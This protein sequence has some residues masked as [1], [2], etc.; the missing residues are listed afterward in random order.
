MKE[1]LL[2]QI[3][4]YK[5]FRAKIKALYYVS[6][7]VNW[8][9]ETV[10]PRDCFDYR[11]EQM[12]IINEELIKTSLSTEYVESINYIYNN[13]EELEDDVL[14]HEIIEIK[15]SNDKMKKIPME[16][17]V[18][19]SIL[20]SKSV[21]VWKDAKKNNSFK[22]FLPVLSEIINYQRKYVK[23]LE[24]EDKKGYDILLDEYE[25]GM[26]T[27][28]YDE[29]FN[30]LKEKLVPFLKK[31]LER[32]NDFDYKF[33]SK[34]YKVE[35]QKKVCEYFRD[36]MCFDKNKGIMIETEH[37]FTDKVGTND[38][39][40][41]VH[42]YEKLF[43]SSIY[44]VI[45]ETGHATYEANIDKSLEGTFSDSGASMAMHESQ[46]RFYENI[47]GKNELFLKKHYPFIKS[48]YKNNLKD[49]SEEY[50]VRYCNL[51]EASYIRTEADELTYPIH[52]MLRYDLEKKL[53]SGE[54]KVKDLEKEWNKLFFEYFGLKVKKS[55]EGVLQDTHWAGGSFGYFPTYA[56][57]SAYAAQFLH[58]MK[59]DINF[60]EAVSKDNTEEINNWLKEHI[61][62]Y[63]SSKDPKE[64][65]KI[66]TGED[67]NPNYYVD[68]LI[69]KYS[70]L[71]N[72]K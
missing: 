62:K 26:S 52:I 35:D 34:K 36:V 65:I 48:V 14:K 33:A 10:A 6:S 32:G 66:A 28:E 29:F 9:S 67:F 50:F 39:R 30:V 18:N 72:I 2:K 19:Y 27:K 4:T 70:K 38:V 71:Y 11:A 20:L 56:L 43:T 7:V 15:K 51:V 16:E 68:Y 54:L 25:N 53:I 8:D 21:S 46:S 37:P 40:I 55:S 24:T 1:E 64:I 13:K 45:H 59:K 22:E 31:V 69:E 47:V 61:H 63:G 42:Y 12:G 17:Q 44:S 58:A 41:T 5:K 49:V 3:E 57:G 23:Y 60:D